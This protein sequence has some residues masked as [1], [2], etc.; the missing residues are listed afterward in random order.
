MGSAGIL[1]EAG[2]HKKRVLLTGAQ[3]FTGQHVVPLL[4][5]AG[6]D[7]WSVDRSPVSVGGLIA[8]G[9]CLQADLLDD[10]AL[11]SAVHQIS[12]QAVIHLAAIAFVGHGS[13]DDFYRVNVLGTRHLLQALSALPVKPQCVLLASSANIYG[14][15]HEGALPEISSAN[16]ANDYAVSK[17]AMEYMAQLW[18]PQLPVVLVRP[19]NYTGLG[20][21]PQFLIPKIVAH[22]M[23]KADLIELGNL[24]VDRDFSDVR[25]VAAAYVRLLDSAMHGDVAG[26]VFNVGSGRTWSLRDVLAQ[27]QLISGHAMEVQVN[28]VFV[29]GNEVRTLRAD[30]TALERAIGE[31][32]SFTLEDTLRWMLQ[33]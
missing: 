33:G 17:L 19:F 23:R 24:D 20:Q 21:S 5:A 9:Q 32:R 14:N 26:R 8:A 16:P 3:G 30:T 15:S 22:A 28:P 12:P 27:V 29:R 31:W 7:V 2:S 11:Q 25:D 10:A 6:W 4:R 13:A 1:M 18:L